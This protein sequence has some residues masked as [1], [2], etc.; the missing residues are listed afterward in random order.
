[1]GMRYYNLTKQNEVKNNS[2][3]IQSVL[4]IQNI[5]IR[6]IDYNTLKRQLQPII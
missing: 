4:I 2:P 5:K 6:T 1:M 3:L